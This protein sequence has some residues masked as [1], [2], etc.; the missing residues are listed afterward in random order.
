M[1]QKIIDWNLKRYPNGEYCGAV[2][3]SLP[4]SLQ[5]SFSCL[6]LVGL[7]FV[8]LSRTKP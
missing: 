8:S 1:A 4:S 5:A 2:S 6:V 7:V 3:K